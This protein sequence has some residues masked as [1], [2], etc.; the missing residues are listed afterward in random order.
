ML[1]LFLLF[2]QNYSQSFFFFFIYIYFPQ[3]CA[4]YYITFL[5]KHIVSLFC[6]F[7]KDY[8]PVISLISIVK[9]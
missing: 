7:H 2:L 5:N 4:P 8:N 3:I 6:V 9:L 1:D